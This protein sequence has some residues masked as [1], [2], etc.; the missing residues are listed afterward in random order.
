[1]K[2]SMTVM[3]GEGLSQFYKDAFPPGTIIQRG[4]TRLTWDSDNR[5]EVDA[6][7][8]TFDKLIAKGFTAFSVRKDGDKGKKLTE[9]DPSIEAMILVPPIKGGG[10]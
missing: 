2:H 6:H 8:A 7:K 9:W 5:E 4:D 10:A 3:V 1:M